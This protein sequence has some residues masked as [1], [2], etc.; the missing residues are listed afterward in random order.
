MGKMNVTRSIYAGCGRRLQVVGSARR[1]AQFL[2]A[3]VASSAALLG[4]PTP[5]AFAEPRPDV[6]VVFAR[7]TYEPPGVGGV[8][9]AFVDSVRAQ[10]GPRSVAVYGVDYAA[11]GDFPA[12]GDFQGGCS[13][14]V[15]S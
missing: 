9:Q 5:F 12:P 13:S 3:V 2:A 10:A 15:P 6:D 7:G 1:I 14:S 11:S 4:S 8:G